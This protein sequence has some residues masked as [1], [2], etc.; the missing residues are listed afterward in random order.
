MSNKIL[1]SIF[2]PATTGVYDI[3]VPKEITVYQATGLISQLLAEREQRFFMPTNSI[4]LYDGV[5]GSEL[6][7]DAFVGALGLCNGARL[8]L[9]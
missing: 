3:W 9:V 6:R 4:A 5:S 2:L 7:A 1:F 8:I